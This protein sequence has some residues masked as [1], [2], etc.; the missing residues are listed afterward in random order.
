MCLR[1]ILDIR[2]RV[3]RPRTSRT[4]RFQE[5]RLGPLISSKDRLFTLVPMFRN[6]DHH[7]VREAFEESLVKIGCEYIDL[8]L[9]HWPQA[10]TETGLS[11]VF[12]L[13]F[14]CT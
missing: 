1:S 10:I 11:L 7:R 8:Y 13:V 2:H 4:S 9:V 14:L 3:L 5:L 6:G 12:C